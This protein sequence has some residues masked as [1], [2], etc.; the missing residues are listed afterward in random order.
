[1]RCTLPA[2]SRIT[3]YCRR[4]TAGFA[5]F[6][7]HALH[8]VGLRLPPQFEGDSILTVLQ[9]I[10]FPRHRG[11]MISFVARPVDDARIPPRVR[12][13]WFEA[14]EPL[15]V[16]DVWQ[17][18]IRLRR[19]RGTSN[20]GVFDYEA[21]LFRERV[22]AT[23]YVV[24]GQRNKR[25]QPAAGNSIG[26]LRRHIVESQQNNGCDTRNPEPATSWPSRD[27]TSAWRQRLP[28]FW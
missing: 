26:R 14:G 2:L 7:L 23:G 24:N 12:L 1:M 9:V 5:L 22:G 11:G 21:W 4:L 15:Q 10:D 19:P 18:E 20:P 16:G 8:V 17:L 25:L 3:F 28:G 6:A 27:C 13:N